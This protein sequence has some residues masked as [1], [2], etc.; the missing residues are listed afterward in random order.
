[1]SLTWYGESILAR[2]K[3]KATEAENITAMEVL[4]RAENITPVRSGDARASLQVEKAT[5][6]THARVWAGSKKVWYFHFIE[7][8][9]KRG[10]RAYRPMRKALSA[11]KRYFLHLMQYVV[12]K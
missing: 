2:M 7:F 12:P 8:G 10:M 6:T 9:T 1:M 5:A 4:R 3:R 11:S